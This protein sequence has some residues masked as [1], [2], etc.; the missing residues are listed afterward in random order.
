MAALEAGIAAPSGWRAFW[1]AA[2]PRTLSVAVAPVLV[3]SALAAA[4]GR[5]RPVAAAAALIGALLIQIGTNLVND[6]VDGLRGTDGTDRIGPPRATQL[7]LIPPQRLRAAIA[8]VFALSLVPGAV[9][10]AVAG[11]PVAL[12]GALCIAA[13]VAYTAGPFPLGHH[14]LGDVAVFAFFG[15]VAVGGSYYVQ[16]LS[17]PP[18]VL[19]ASLPLAAL[20]TAVL[21]V[22]NLR[23]LD[24]DRRAGKRTLA[25]RIGRRASRV[26]YAA[27]LGLAY[28]VPPALLAAG[29]ATP[30]VL[31]PLV[32][33]P[34]AIRLVGRVARSS[35]GPALNAALART[36]RLELGFA[37]LFAFG[38]I[39]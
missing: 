8:I 10:V 1:L 35:D 19:V 37:F 34:L 21:V 5:A 32:T 17:L 25:V 4:D 28:A 33:L 24:A 31:L 27:L 18:R 11:W 12:L 16:A 20:S 38:L 2:R 26:E 30:A 13:G 15:L 14:G 39:R 36:A 22:N 6:L 29:S 7:G 9:L 23:D 3:G